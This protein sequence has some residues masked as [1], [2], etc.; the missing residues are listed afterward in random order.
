MQSMPLLAGLPD[1]STAQQRCK[2]ASRRW[3]RTSA[4]LETLLATSE[5]SQRVLT[6]AVR[7]E[8]WTQCR[9]S[10]LFKRPYIPPVQYT[11]MEANAH[12]TGTYRSNAK[13]SSCV[14]CGQALIGRRVV[15]FHV[16]QASRTTV[17]ISISE[18]FL[19]ASSDDG[20]VF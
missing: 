20:H 14:L 6:C 9:D 18:W 3:I 4:E 11:I 10:N 5:F 1:T 7:T 12:E 2:H 13:E 8:I 17:G 15:L 19:S 16:R